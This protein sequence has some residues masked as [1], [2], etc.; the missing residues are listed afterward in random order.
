MKLHHS[1]IAAALLA[2]LAACGQK[3]DAAEEQ[4]A[5]KSLLGQIAAPALEAVREDLAKKNLRLDERGIGIAGR[6]GDAA[7]S[8]EITPEGALI[9]HGKAV[10]ITPAQQELLLQYRQ[11]LLAVA[12]AGISTG[13]QGV[14]LG[15]LALQS[16]PALI[17]GD[18]KAVEAQLRAEAEKIKAKAG[19]ICQQLSPL[20]AVQERLVETLPEFRP[21]ARLDQAE[22]ERC[23]QETANAAAP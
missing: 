23:L 5:P 12:E 7:F 16:L 11:S 6:D 17:R 3:T 21:Y 1:L 8:A 2:S 13:L 9:L 20:L 15:D 14:D 22:I 4:G 18:E 10:E 19:T